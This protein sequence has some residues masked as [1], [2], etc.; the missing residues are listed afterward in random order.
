MSRAFQIPAETRGRDRRAWCTLFGTLPEYFL[1]VL[2]V[3]IALGILGLVAW[4]NQRAAQWPEAEGTIEAARLEDIKDQSNLGGYRTVLVVSYS[5]QVNGSFY[6]GYQQ[7]PFRPSNPYSYLVGTQVQVRY[8]P[9]RPE[10]SRLLSLPTMT[11]SA[12]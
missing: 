10:T 11:K 6:G 5:Y 12:G 2:G 3:L 7:F 4:R 1:T 9:G 8:K